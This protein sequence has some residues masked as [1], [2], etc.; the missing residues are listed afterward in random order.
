MEELGRHIAEIRRDIK[1][2][3]DSFEGFANTY[4]PI[5]DKLMSNDLY[6]QRVREDVVKTTARSVVW[7]L[8]CG[9]CIAVWH[10]AQDYVIELAKIASK[11]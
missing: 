10:A 4:R 2:L 8:L 11:K 5:L 3:H 9:F 7:V 1:C 6:W